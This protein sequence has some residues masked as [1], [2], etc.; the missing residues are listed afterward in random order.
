MRIREVIFQGMYGCD[1]PVRLATAPGLDRMALPADLSVDQ[2]HDLL[3]SLFYP[4]RISP[5]LQRRFEEGGDIKLAAV[6]ERNGRQFRVLRK[7][8]PATL[9]LQVERD[10]AFKPHTRGH[11]DT[12]EVLRERVG[13]P[14]FPTFAALNLW[15]FDDDELFSRSDATTGETERELIEKYRVAVRVEGL[16]DRIKELEVELDERRE[17]LGKGAK[18]EKK[19]EQARARLDE[20]DLSDLSDEDMSLLEDKERRFEEFE[21]QLQRLE[22]QEEEARDEIE[23]ELPTRPWREGVFWAGLALGLAALAVSIVFADSLRPVAAV[24]VVGSGLVAWVLLRY[25]NGLEQ[26]AV[27]QARL[28]S[29]KRRLNQVREQQARF[30]EKIN[31]VLIHAGV[32]S[33]HELYERVEKTRK[34]QEIIEQLEARAAEIRADESYRAAQAEIAELEEELERLTAE[35]AELPEFVM[36]AFQLENDL[37][38]LGIDPN[39]A[40]EE[41]DDEDE[42]I[43]ETTFGRLGH[44]ARTTG[45]WGDDGLAEPVRKMWGKICARLLG[46]RFKGV[47]LSE[48]DELTVGEFTSDQLEMWRRT[49]S[50]QERLVAAALALALQVGGANALETVWVRDPGAVFGSKIADGFDAVFESAARKSHVVLCRKAESEGLRG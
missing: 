25:F 46:A 42:A 9:R 30:R 15:R 36:S 31:H 38:T 4:G 19:L 14:D 22:E 45:Q 43:A 28:T 27:H 44:V 24:N 47:D 34:L 35:R 21:R 18:V 5:A 23:R 37:E 7:A 49:R 39:E 13:F 10:G 16:E 32:E 11:T 20:I 33:E 17:A 12:V 48:D 2:V 1:S 41:D 40:L 3:L 6:V 26:A 50:S 29:I 8:D